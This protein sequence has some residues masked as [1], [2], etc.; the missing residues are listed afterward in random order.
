MSQL[1]TETTLV[2]I[3]SKC[4]ILLYQDYLAYFFYERQL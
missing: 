3:I 1:T 2:L 4:T